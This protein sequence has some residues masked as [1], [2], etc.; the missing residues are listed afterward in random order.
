MFQASFSF[1][2]LRKAVKSSQPNDFSISAERF[3]VLRQMKWS[4]A[5]RYLKHP[6]FCNFNIMRGLYRNLKDEG[7]FCKIPVYGET[8]GLHESNVPYR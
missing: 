3:S 1:L 8:S 2:S 7:S 5:E 6:S 4:L